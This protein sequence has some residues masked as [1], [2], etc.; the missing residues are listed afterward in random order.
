MAEQRAG[1]GR[2]RLVP[3]FFSAAH[4]LA[5]TVARMT[6]V[7]TTKRDSREFSMRDLGPAVKLNRHL[8]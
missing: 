4:A 2:C 1:T 3:G 6:V 8:W 5:E 7:N